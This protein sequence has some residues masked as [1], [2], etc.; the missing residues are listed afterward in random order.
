[1]VCLI[2][3]ADQYFNVTQLI[4]GKPQALPEWLIYSNSLLDKH[5]S[6]MLN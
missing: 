1:M 3:F 2:F 5:L 6:G 4:G